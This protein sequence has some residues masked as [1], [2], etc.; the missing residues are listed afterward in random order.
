MNCKPRI[1]AIINEKN[2]CASSMALYVS[3]RAQNYKNGSYEPRRGPRMLHM[4]LPIKTS[5]R[6]SKPSPPDAWPKTT[7]VL[8][9]IRKKH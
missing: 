9:A 7:D 4:Q 2:S 1:T 5:C 8:S 3:N 6:N